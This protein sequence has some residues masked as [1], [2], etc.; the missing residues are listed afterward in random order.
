MKIKYVIFFVNLVMLAGSTVAQEYEKVDNTQVKTLLGGQ[1]KVQGFGS[2]DLKVSQWN[3]QTALLVGG[4]GGVILNNKFTIGLGG[5]GITTRAKFKSL[6]NQENLYLSGG[7]GGLLLGYSIFSK[8]IF[9]LNFPILF[10][11]GGLDILEDEDNIFSNGFDNITESTG[12]FIVEP[13]VELEIN[14]ASF[15]RLAIGGTYRFIEGANLDNINN[16]DLEDWSTHISF[17]FGKF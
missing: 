16:S 14:V 12:F 11:G 4:H 6:D 13:G 2:V 7:Y 10:G 8:E 5:Y 1:V 15:F 3:K 9:H 17:K